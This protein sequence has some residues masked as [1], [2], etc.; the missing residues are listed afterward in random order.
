MKNM[1]KLGN[2]KKVKFVGPKK[3]V[4]WR[5]KACG[6]RLIWKFAFSIPLLNSISH[7]MWNKQ[8]LSLPCAISVHGVQM[9]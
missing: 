3:S 7:F 8:A 9:Y 6:P 1:G 2:D 4:R 5:E